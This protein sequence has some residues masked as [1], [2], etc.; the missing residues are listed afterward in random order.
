VERNPH[1][2][3]RNMCWAL[4]FKYRHASNLYCLQNTIRV[5]KKKIDEGDRSAKE[6]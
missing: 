5:N 2:V 3:P 6:N 4:V 1:Y